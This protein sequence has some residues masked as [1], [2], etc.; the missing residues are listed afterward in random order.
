MIKKKKL[1]DVCVHAG[2]WVSEDARGRAPV[3]SRMGVF[4]GRRRGVITPAKRWFTSTALGA[5]KQGKGIVR[6]ER[7]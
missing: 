5:E 1:K 7:G 3:K 2:V 6:E 4:F